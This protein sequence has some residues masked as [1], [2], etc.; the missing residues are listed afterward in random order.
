M[1]ND[2]P[3]NEF[4]RAALTKIITPESIVVEIGTGSGLLSMIAARLGAK[5]VTAIE[6]N[7]H[8]AAIAMRNFEANGLADRITV[9]N[10][11]STDVREDELPHGRATVLVS[12]I[13]GTLLL[14][15]SALEF[16]ADARK[17]LLQPDAKIVPANGSQFVA[18]V[19]SADLE[20]IT[21]VRN[22]GGFDLVGFNCLKD[23]ASVV[24]TKQYGFRFSSVSHNFL[25][26]RVSIADVDF[27]VDEFEPADGALEKRFRVQALADGTAH[28]AIFSWEVH[29][30][31]TRAVS[32]TTHPEDTRDNFAR[33]MQWGQALQLLEDHTAPAVAEG[34]TPV[35]LVVSAG[36]WLDIIVKY[37]T[38]GVLIQTLVE[39]A[40][41]PP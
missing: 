12:E 6:A 23:T 15:E 27:H 20:S 31:A 25:T 33:D 28:A 32:M 5:H 29:S 8:L 40:P 14:G 1:L 10:K 21:T 18:I 3:R 17:H 24:F 7:D 11:M 30:D 4:Y 13:L 35:P 34:G 26:E 19:E 2:H 9:I 41:G 38:N 22:W 39:R 16:T 37:S 36:E